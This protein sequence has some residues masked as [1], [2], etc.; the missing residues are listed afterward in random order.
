VTMSSNKDASLVNSNLR[1]DVA[2]VRSV[3]D[4]AKQLSEPAGNATQSKRGRGRPRKVSGVTAATKTF[5]QTIRMTP[6]L[7]RALRAA[8][9][10]E[11]DRTSSVVSVHD[12]IL[13]A[14]RAHLKREG[15]DVPD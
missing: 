7:R 5:G 11:T 9:D 2:D 12:I 1:S 3:D 6:G 14:V 15:I 4:V 10:A 13:K 8:A